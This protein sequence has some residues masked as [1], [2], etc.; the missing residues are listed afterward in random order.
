M[1]VLLLSSTGQPISLLE[2]LARGG[3][4]SVWSTNQPGLVAKL[5]QQ[6]TPERFKKLEV[7]VANPPIDPTKAQN[8]TSIVWPK[9]LLKDNQGAYQG[10]VMPSIPQ[11]KEL[12][13]VYTPKLRKAFA[14]EFNWQYLHTTAQNL[15]LTIQAIH[16]GGYVLG[17]INPR[18]ILVNRQA[19][20][21]IIDTDSFQVQDPKDGKIY[22]CTVGMAE[23]TPPELINQDFSTLSQTPLQDH[24]RLGIIIHY[25]LFGDHPFKG[26]W[27]GPGDSPNPIASISRGLWPYGSDRQMVAGP[28]NIPL[29]VVHPALK[30]CFLECFNAGHGQPDRRPTARAWYEALT[31][32]S[33]DLKVCSRNKNHYYAGH[34]GKCYWCERGQTLNFDVFALPNTPV[35]TQVSKIPLSKKSSP[36]TVASATVQT[37]ASPKVGPSS[38]GNRTSVTKF[39]FNPVTIILSV[40]L[41]FFTVVLVRPF[42]ITSPAESYL[43]QGIA[44]YEAG[45]NVKALEAYNQSLKLDPQYA[46]AYKHRGIVYEKLEEKTKALADYN[47]ALKLDPQYINAY[48]RRGLFY[49]NT[50]DKIKALEDYDQV[51][52]LDPEYIGAYLN[53]GFLYQNMGENTKALEDYNQ[54]L[55]LDHGNT[56]TY[57]N[58]AIVYEKLGDSTKVLED[59]D[60]VLQLDPTYTDAYY[61]RAGF[62]QK[63]GDNTKALENYNHVLKLDSKYINAYSNRGMVYT[64]LG[65]NTKALEDY[66]QVLKLDSKDAITY[67]NR[68]L[69]YESLGDKIK[70]LS[71]Y[72]QALR[73][74]PKY[75]IAYNNRGNL[76]R[77]L[78]EKTKALE[79][80]NKALKLNPKNVYAYNNRGL[81]YQN[82]ENNTKALED[83]NQ[84]LKLDPSFAYAYANRGILYEKLGEKT[85]ALEDYHQAMKLNPKLAEV[86]LQ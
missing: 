63:T 72:N 65:D 24:F 70:A 36:Q 15:A 7:M 32:A 34:Y 28:L 41:L 82:L 61:N 5:Y 18:N 51:L 49:Q 13:K 85:K 54:V 80:L 45:N 8:H 26:K 69:I 4:G 75:A 9:D 20:P 77:I 42:F 60:Q 43:G 1:K 10:F 6:P 31:Q 40:V 79:D 76:Y 81:V 56:N 53:R 17:D 67:Y 29:E 22:R 59:Y 47:Q 30:D 64:N 78:G 55:K 46:Y 39:F 68:G 86:L 52:Q 11:G 33:S 50:G 27:I 74:D 2:E 16:D 66:N 48:F 73:F 25:L 83:Y 38:T 84:A 44:Y 14:P 23:F 62:Y 3:E 35:T 19:L 57:Y 58:R 12:P 21:S 37:G 71:D